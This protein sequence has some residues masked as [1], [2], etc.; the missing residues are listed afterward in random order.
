MTGPPA[1]SSPTGRGA[2]VVTSVPDGE[3]TG[4]GPVVWGSAGDQ[5]SKIQ[6]TSRTGAITQDG[7]AVFRWA[8]SLHPLALQ[9][10]ARAG[11]LPSDLSAFVP[12]QANLRI[13]E[14]PRPQARHPA[15]AGSRRHR[16]RG[17]HL[18]GVGAAGAGP[19]GRAGA[20]G[21][22][23]PGAADGI[24]RGAV[25][26]GAGDHAT[27]NVTRRRRVLIKVHPIPTVHKE[28]TP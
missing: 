25:L 3:P 7:Q 4:I 2:A 5:G 19:D 21:I 8:T 15:R 16:A 26:R 10:C 17:E 1:S 13:I 22:R 24:R 23:H 9:A 11:V 12:H 28:H 20:A 14:G 27:V 6:V 18:V